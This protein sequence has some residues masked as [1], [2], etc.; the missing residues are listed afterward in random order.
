[1]VGIMDGNGWAIGWKDGNVG[2]RW[3]GRCCLMCGAGIDGIAD[4][5]C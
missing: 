4:G 2:G 3:Q 5:V 1:M